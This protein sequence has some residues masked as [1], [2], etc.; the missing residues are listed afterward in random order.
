[1]SKIKKQEIQF[2]ALLP[3]LQNPRQ[4][5]KEIELQES[6]RHISKVNAL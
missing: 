5:A 2:Q 1:M 6:P 4:N 3:R